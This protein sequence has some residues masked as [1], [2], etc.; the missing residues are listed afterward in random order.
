[1]RPIY[2]IFEGGF[3]L[4]SYWAAYYTFDLFARRSPYLERP[5]YGTVIGGLLFLFFGVLTTIML[6]RE[7]L[8]GVL[9]LLKLP[10]APGGASAALPAPQTQLATSTDPDPED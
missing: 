2:L 4:F 5:D 3:A 1:M 9:R 7:L 6:V 8:P 10:N